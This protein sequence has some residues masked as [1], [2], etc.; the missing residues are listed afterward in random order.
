MFCDLGGSKALTVAPPREAGLRFRQH[1]RHAVSQKGRSAHDDVDHRRHRVYRPAADPAFGEAGRS[2]R[3]HGH[4]PADRQ[5][6]R[7]G[8]G[9]G[10]ARRCQPVRRRDGRDDGGEARPGDQPRLLHQQRPAAARRVQAEHPRHGQ[11]LRGGAPRR[12]QPGRLCQFG[13]GQRRAEILWRA[14]RQRRR[15]QARPPAIR[16][17]QDLQRVAGA[18]LPRKARHGDHDDPPGQCDRPGQ[19]GRLGRPRFLHHDLRRAASPSSSR[20]RTRCARRSTS[21]RSRKS[22]PGWS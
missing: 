1:V 12:V 22:S 18:G 13:G 17:A 8:Q 16:D 14:H 6:Q 7:V 2:F 20:T 5:F 9:A 21:T 3:G 19:G 15:F 10:A 4:Q 11:L